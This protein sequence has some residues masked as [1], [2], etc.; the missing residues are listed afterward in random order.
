MLHCS[1]VD[2]RIFNISYYDLLRGFDLSA[3]PSYYEPWGY[4]PME[5]LAVGVPTVTTSYAGFGQWMES[6]S[7]NITQGLSVVTRT[8]SNYWDVVNEIEAVVLKISDASI[9]ER[10]NINTKAQKLAEETVW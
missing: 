9:T 7:E 8:E 5:S 1:V 3:F 6:K 2:F 10:K 4:T